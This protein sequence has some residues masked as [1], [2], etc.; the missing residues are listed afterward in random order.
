MHAASNPSHFTVCRST[1]S[2]KRDLFTVNFQNSSLVCEHFA[3]A[4]NAAQ[5][6]FME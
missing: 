2:S 1:Q 4:R 6:Q 5:R 3:S